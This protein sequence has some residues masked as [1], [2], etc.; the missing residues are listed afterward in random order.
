MTSAKQDAKAA[1]AIAGL[2]GLVESGK[3]FKAWRAAN[4]ASYLSSIFT[5]ATDLERLSKGGFADA[6]TEWLL[7]YYD[8]DDDTFTTFSSI[9]NQRGTR[10]QAFKKGRSLPK[11]D[12]DAVRVGISK[13]LE[14]G[15]GVKKGNYKGEDTSRVILVLQP[16][17]KNEILAGNESDK[18]SRAS[19][20][21]VAVWNMT[22]ITTSFNVINV[23]IDA[24]SAVVLSHRL[25]GVM[26]FMQKDK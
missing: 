22:Y 26:D 10:E 15:E 7:S 13:C 24:E 14:V 17:T 21:A 18:G 4:K 6:G 11:L 12:V 1:S 25:S 3:E 5:M 9:G 19:R 23:K 20:S 16:L 8:N 2:I